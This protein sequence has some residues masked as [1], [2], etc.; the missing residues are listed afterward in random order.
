MPTN[1]LPGNLLGIEI[2]GKFVACETSCEFTFE[3]DML[4]A[5]AVD[6]GRWK[7]VIAGLRSW[8]ISVNASMLIQSSAT[9]LTSI[10]NAFVSGQRMRVRIK[11][12]VAMIGSILITGYV[13]VQNGGLSAAVNSTTTW[14]TTLQGDGAF[15][16]GDSLNYQMFYG[17]RL[18]DPYG[19][20]LLLQPQFT[21]EF[22]FGSPSISLDFTAASAANYLFAI[23]PTG[24]P[25]FNRWEN[26]EYNFGDIP[27]FAW[28]EVRTINGFDYYIS[29]SILYIT[30]AVPAIT[31]RYKNIIP[32]Q[33]Y[34]N[35]IID[36]LLNT[37]YE[38]NPITVEGL[39]EP[40]LATVTNGE[41][42]INNGPWVTGSFYVNSGNSIKTR[43]TSSSSYTTAVG[44][45]LTINGISDTFDV[46]TAQNTTIYYAYN[47]GIFIRNNCG[48]DSNG[49]QVPY[50]KQYTAVGSQADAD[51]IAAADLANFNIEGQN[52][53]NSTG[54]C[55]ANTIYVWG[56][57]F[58]ENFQTVSGSTYAD[59]FLR[60]YK[61]G[62]ATTPPSDLSQP[63]NCTN[64]TI[65]I[66]YY[67]TGYP[68][69]TFNASMNNQQEIRLAAPNTQNG[70]PVYPKQNIYAS[71]YYA[72]IAKARG[73]W[74]LLQV[75]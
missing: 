7:E 63:V 43:I 9:D 59:V 56:K 23:V 24:Q 45:T 66:G 58:E 72:F 36:A 74:T 22:Q 8:S 1:K 54:T 73:A 29:R 44:V 70:N 65:P 33:F 38:S 62:T 46:T 15:Q 55:T 20:E 68:P 50:S 6:S 40:V 10:I 49:S 21:K 27:D 4:D 35:D 61:G 2:D 12:K 71:L 37:V 5:S 18:E 13:I 16:L 42:S 25:V 51:S 31:F 3:A 39:T 26:N 41:A 52:N 64:L 67:L 53:A 28:R 19:D 30:S 47:N 32:N 60:T 14:N 11:T 34:F 57:I 75:I 17:Y 69:N 48:V